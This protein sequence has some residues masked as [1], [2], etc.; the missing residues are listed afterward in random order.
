MNTP[1]QSAVNSLEAALAKLC[2]SLEAYCKRQ[3][4]QCASADEMLML[5]DLKPEQRRWLS[6]F[7]DAWDKITD[8]QYCIGRMKDYDNK[9]AA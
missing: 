7:S 2:E 6:E 3:G 9:A 4:L 8:G 1:E 5:E